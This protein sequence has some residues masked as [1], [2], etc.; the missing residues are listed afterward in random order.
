MA[1]A[2][3]DWE[4]PAS[5]TGGSYLGVCRFDISQEGADASARDKIIA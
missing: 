5:M 4:P 3:I 2:E 1:S